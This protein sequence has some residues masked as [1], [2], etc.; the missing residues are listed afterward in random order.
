ME[1]VHPILWW[2]VAAAA[3]P[4]V[5]HLLLRQ[6]PR[7]RPWAAM[8]WLKAA[9]DQASRTWKLTNLLL[10][11]L[12]MAVLACLAAAVARPLIGM[13]A[14]GGA[15]LVVVDRSASMG[16]RGEDPG[17][18]ATAVA[19]LANADLPYTRVVVAVTPGANGGPCSIIADGG[20]G[21]VRTLGRSL[22]A[23]ELPGGL[24]GATHD[25]AALDTAL[26]GP[27]PD[28][29]LISD[30]QQD[31]GEALVAGLGQRCGRVHRWAPGAPTADNAWIAGLGDLPDLVPGQPGSLPVRLAG[32]ITGATLSMDGG[33]FLAVPLPDD[34]ADGTRTLDLPLPALSAGRHDLRVTV[35]D[36]GLTTDNR[37]EVPLTV[38]GP[39]SVLLVQASPLATDYLPAALGADPA[40]VSRRILRPDALATEPLTDGLLIVLRAPVTP[41]TAERLAAWVR[42]G[43]ALWADLRLLREDPV[44]A[45]LIDLTPGAPIA[46]GAY[47]AGQ[48]DLDPLLRLG[49]CERLPSVVPPAT[50]TFELTAGTAPAALR[51][52]VGT[53]SV[54]VEVAAL[55]R[56]EAFQA[57]GGTPLWT[58]RLARR[59]TAHPPTVWT[60]GLPAPA[61]AA[62]RRDGAAVTA[63]RGEPLRAAPGR[64]T[65][66][67]GDGVTVLP[68]PAEARLDRPTGLPA[69]LRESLPS[70]GGADLGPWLLALA[71]ILALIEG[72][73]AA[74]AGRSY[75]R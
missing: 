64:W 25:L 74:W 24:D 66:D 7:P 45:R 13:L 10:L 6:R 39:V 61:D 20:P 51:L 42:R 65:I 30:F 34:R 73:V 57:R 67:G 44:L 14:G 27:R 47:A 4:V 37:L 32:R 46:G 55:G 28:V 18:L 38:R 31:Q 59:L 62:L 36:R 63:T 8:R 53:G 68:N 21:A 35:Q 9:A 70:G 23:S 22:A 50:A 16:P 5:L 48:A 17:P 40:A 3:L 15:L 29:L 75:G 12:R 58:L 26:T 72:A 60:A 69:D 41:A 52:A 43:G 71:L 2:G 33:P 56:E 1:A 11:L 49:G 19:A 54:L